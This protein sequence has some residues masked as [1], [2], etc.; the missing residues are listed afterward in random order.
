MWLAR[1]TLDFYFN[2]LCKFYFFP[3]YYYYYYYY[4]ELIPDR[5]TT[6]LHCPLSCM[7]ACISSSCSPVSLVRVSCSR[8]DRVPKS[9]IW[10]SIK[11]A[12]CTEKSYSRPTVT[13]AQCA[14][15]QLST[16]RPVFKK[17][18]L[19][20]VQTNL[21]QHLLRCF[22]NLVRNFVTVPKVNTCNIVVTSAHVGLCQNK[23]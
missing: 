2:G 16:F 19:R 6:V 11:S 9:Q 20:N 7:Q 13:R 17:Y 14:G 21:F 18:P 3:T 15:A 1:S 23:R 10:S 22:M 12:V 4:V 5:A 8:P